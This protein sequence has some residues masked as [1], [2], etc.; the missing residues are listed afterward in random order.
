MSTPVLRTYQQEAAN[1]LVATRSGVAVEPT[2]SGKSLV[3]ADVVRQCSPCLIMQPSQEILASN[4]EKI[5]AFGFDD[6]AIYSAGAGSKETAA[7]T[8]ATIGSIVKNGKVVPE[9]LALKPKKLIIDEC[10][11]VNPKGG[12]Y[13]DLITQ[14]GC[15]LCGLTATPYRLH[16]IADPNSFKAHG[17]SGR[18]FPTDSISDIRLITRTR[19]KMFSK[20][21]HVTQPAELLAAGFLHDPEFVVR[22][23]KTRAE[24]KTNKTGAEFS[25]ASVSS[26]FRKSK[27]KD[28]IVMTVQ[29]AMVAGF[30]HILVFVPRLEVSDELVR[31]LQR[32]GIAADN[33]DG[34]TPARIREDRVRGFRSGRIQVMM[35]V[36]TLTTGFDLPRLDCIIGAR[37]TLSLALYYQMIGRCVRP[38]P[39]KKVARVY[40]L[41]NNYERF[42]NPLRL[43]LVPGSTG[44]HHILG[45]GGRLTGRDLAA[46]PE[47]EDKVDWGK[48]AGSKLKD[49]PMEYLFWV[50][51]NNKP[52][53]ERHQIEAEYQRRIY[54]CQ[55]AAHGT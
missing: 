18:I 7:A 17:K 38:H 44:L 14:L 37:P 10:H 43:R 28:E 39:E 30:Q 16:T 31:R 34:E 8:Y 32:L 29:E 42:G 24:L 23:H 55:E 13:A 4:V 40:D 41:V 20:M 51:N 15:D 54:F 50:I 3:I 19:P 35:N 25:D 26:F 2:G 11:L 36:G 22:G 5:K 46:G 45:P 48:Y 27:I 12:Q 52:S 47:C 1:A 9:I 6:V 53:E 21:V 49:L 33:I